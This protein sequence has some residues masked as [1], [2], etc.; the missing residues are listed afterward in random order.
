MIIPNK[1]IELKYSLLG[2]GGRLLPELDSSQTVSSLWDKVREY[3]EIGSFT[4]F[5]LAL[6]L[7]YMLGLVEIDNG[8]IKKVQ[9]NDKSS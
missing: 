4:K 7:L 2:V 1:T 5:V 9:K 3:E 8:V 6:D